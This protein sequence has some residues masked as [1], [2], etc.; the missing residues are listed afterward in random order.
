MQCLTSSPL[1]LIFLLLMALIL[2]CSTGGSSSNYNTDPR[3]KPPEKQLAYLDGGLSAM[4][5]DTKVARYRY[6]LENIS[7]K[8][9][10]SKASISDLTYR[11]T[12]ALA[13]DYGKKITNLEFLEQANIFLDRSSVKSNYKDLSTMLIITMGK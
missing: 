2:G 13:S 6:L 9:G 4:N 11:S 8:T 10:D 12:A 1:F 5:D 3:N 7:N